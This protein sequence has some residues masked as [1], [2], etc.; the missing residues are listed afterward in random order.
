MSCRAV[1]AL[2][3]VAAALTA[4]SGSA[5]APASAA[6]TA[7]PTPSSMNIPAAS[8]QTVPGCPAG[9]LV[10]DAG[11]LKLA[12]RSALPG[13]VILLAPGTYTGNFVAALPGTETAPIILCGTREAVLNGGGVKSGYTLHLNAASWWHLVGF[14]VQG[15]QKGV[16]VDHANH[17]LISRL[18]LHGIGDEAI[19]LR[20]FS[21]D[22]VV[23][24]VIIRGTGLLRA[25]FGEGIY[26]GSASSNWCVY[27]S[28]GPD[29]SDRNVIRD[30]DISQ[31]T[32]E[33]IDIKEGT[34]GGFVTGNRLSGVG[35]DSSAARAWLNAKGNQWTII[36]NVGERSVAD[37]FQVHQVA[38]GWGVQNVF[39][40]NQAAVDG[41]GFGFYVQ[42]A[43]LGTIIGCDN[44]ASGAGSGFS[45]TGC[46]K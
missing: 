14:T 15:G 13:A 19:H 6:L 25:K 2:L 35:M 44:V 36:A 20:A 43:F 9:Q 26:I 12:L 24:N 40:A 23:E 42:F 21:S 28:C 10:S 17:V 30:N 16:V 18:Y 27:S 7:S 1:I 38:R 22:N 11:Q 41:P 45:N 34:T 3:S 39:H 4:C 31:T 29:A 8:Q 33:N 46:T 5:K 32:A 37:G